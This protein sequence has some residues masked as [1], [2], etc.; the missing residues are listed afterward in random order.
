VRLP[1]FE[2]LTQWLDRIV[3][4][5]RVKR[6]VIAVIEAAAWQGLYAAHRDRLD[7]PSTTCLIAQS[8]SGDVRSDVDAT[9]VILLLGALSRVPPAG[10][11]PVEEGHHGHS[12]RPAHTVIVQSAAG[13]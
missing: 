6:G 10:W 3:E 12:S 9:D 5:A 11:G 13:R 7:Q 1:H 4:Y 2:D 8:D